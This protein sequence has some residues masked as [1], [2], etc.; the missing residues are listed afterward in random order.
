MRNCKNGRL[1]MKEKPREGNKGMTDYYNSN[2]EKERIIDKINGKK[3][4]KKLRSSEVKE[5]MT[6]CK[7]R[8]VSKERVT[9]C[10]D[11]RKEK[12]NQ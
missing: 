2:E 11:I 5:R 6:I 3:G 1:G 9:H 10:K 4:T 12:N 7:D 8:K